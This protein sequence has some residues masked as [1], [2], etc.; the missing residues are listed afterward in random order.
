[1][2]THYDVQRHRD[3]CKNRWQIIHKATNSIVT[4]LG[5]LASCRKR[6]AV[7]FRNLAES[8]APTDN[9]KKAANDLRKA[10]F[11]EKWRTFILE[12]HGAA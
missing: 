10:G 11:L 1:M 9:P 4:P 2:A 8:M 5:I 12:S 7:R 3:G 6:D